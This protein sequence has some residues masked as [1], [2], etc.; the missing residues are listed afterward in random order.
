MLLSMINDKS[1]KS[2]ESVGIE[3][4]WN[5][6]GGYITIHSK[7]LTICIDKKWSGVLIIPYWYTFWF[8]TSRPRLIVSHS[9]IFTFSQQMIPLIKTHDLFF[10]L[11]KFKAF[12]LIHFF[13]FSI[14]PLTSMRRCISSPKVWT[15][16]SRSMW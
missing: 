2:I 7:G 8:I 6:P 1:E 11:C 4:D 12:V 3:I 10:V 15:S 16:K 13:P 14:L 9:L 5:K